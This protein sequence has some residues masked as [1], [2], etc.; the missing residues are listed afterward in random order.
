M[1]KLQDWTRSI[2]EA[3]LVPDEN[4]LTRSSQNSSTEDIDSDSDGSSTYGARSSSTVST[5]PTQTPT[6]SQSRRFSKDTTSQQSSSYTYDQYY[7]LPDIDPNATMVPLFSG[8]TAYRGTFVSPPLVPNTHWDDLVKKRKEE[9]L[10]RIK[11][12]DLEE[13]SREDVVLHDS[14]TESTE[15]QTVLLSDNVSKKTGSWL[16]VGDETI[17]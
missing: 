9:T 2:A 1:M 3:F 13:E 7:I 8:W 10:E 14:P 5:T 15:Q 11:E 17:L 6:Q 4:H 16:V 12:A